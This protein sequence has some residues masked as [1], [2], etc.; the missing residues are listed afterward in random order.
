M[1]GTPSLWPISN[2]LVNFQMH[3][4]CRTYTLVYHTYTPAR[5]AQVYPNV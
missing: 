5:L 1:W 2:A 4:Y 3:T